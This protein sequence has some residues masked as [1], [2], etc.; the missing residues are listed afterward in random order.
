MY[1]RIQKSGDLIRTTYG[2]TPTRRGVLKGM[3]AG[4]AVGLSG[5]P[6]W[7][8]TNVDYMGWLGYEAFLE[9]DDFLAKHDMTLEK[10]FINAPEEIVARLRLAPGEV[11][12]CVPY[13]IHLDFMAS[14]GLLAPIDTARLS[15]WPDLMQPILDISRE[16]MTYEG[17]WY[18]VPFT[19]S[20]IAIVYNPKYVT[21]VPTSWLDMLKPEYVGKI[22]IPSDLPSAFSTWGRVATDAAE[23]NLM[24]HEQLQQTVDF[25]IEMKKNNMR[26][27]AASYGELVD[28]LAREEIWLAQGGEAVMAWVG[29]EPELAIA[30]PEEGCMTFVEG[31]SLSAGSKNPDAVY[32]LMNQSISLEGQLAG[33]AFNGMP[34]TNAKAIPM[35]DEW[36]RNAYPYDNIETFFT[37][38]LRVDPMYYLEPDGVHATWDDYILAWEEII[39]A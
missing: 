4:V 37:T 26:T 28:M 14:E 30:Y 27:L 36:N 8:A 10:T 13:F 19:W 18:S 34:V 6:A 20:S 38:K 39:K 32:E 15:N 9:A 1:T 24:T 3:A 33:A 7:A 16:N 12:I 35:L 25:I 22:S 17:E 2:H 31:W 11:D 29:E 21:E 5:L 23:P